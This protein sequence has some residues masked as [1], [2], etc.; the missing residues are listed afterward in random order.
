MS[1]PGTCADGCGCGC[2]PVVPQTPEPVDN[3]PGQSSIGYRV[4]RHSS[5]KGAILRGLS[6]HDLPALGGL[7]ARDDV[8]PTIALADGFAAMA[9]VL[10]FY[11]ERLAHESFLR[12]ATERFSVVELS[13]LIGYRPDPGVA[14]DAWLA[15]TVEEARTL[16]RRPAEP[17]AVHVGTQVQS[18]PGQDE[19][20]V[21]FETVAPIVARA[22]WNAVPPA[23]DAWPT[24]L[25]G[26]TSLTLA[27]TGH[28]LARGDRMLLLG[29]TRAV[30]PSGTDW[31]VRVLVD[32]AEDARRDTTVVTWQGAIGPAI[33]VAGATVHVFRL[34]APMF[35]HNAPDP[36]LMSTSG[37]S[38]AE[39]ADVGAGT[40]NDF[41]LPTD[42]VDLDQ[43][44]SEVVTGGW[45]YV[46]QA[47]ASA[48]L[49]KAT[50]V[51][52][53]SRS[54][55][56]LAAKV[57]RVSLDLAF[58]DPP[59]FARRECTV[60]AAS[61]EL[62]L[63]PDELT[64]AVEGREV[65][66]D[67]EVS[68]AAGQPLAVHG[69]PYG[70]GAGA[71]VV[72]EVVLVAE[73]ADAVTVA[74]GRTTVRLA[75]PLS[76]SYDRATSSFNANVA[77]ATEGVS[78]GEILGSGDATAAGQAFVLKQRPLTWTADATGRAS[79]LDIRVDGVLW[80]RRPTLFEAGPDERVYV[81]ETR[82]DSTT[83][84]RFGDG[85]EGARLPTGQANVRAD[86]RT[87]LGEDGNVRA[88]QVTTLLSRPLG[89]TGVTNPAAATGGEDPEPLDLARRNAPVTVRTL[90]RV[91]SLLDVE[92]F[93]RAHPGI[94]K[95]GAVWVPT[96]PARGVV[97]TVTG[98]G[99][100]VVEASAPTLLRLRSALRDAGDPR[101][102]LALM[103]HRPV[104][105]T[106]ALRVLPDPDHVAETVVAGVRAGLLAAYGWES[107]DL[108]QRTS[109]D[110][111]VTIAHGAPG[112]V[113]VDVDRLRR[114]DAPAG[115]E[116]QERVPVH[117]GGLDA[118]TGEP[119]GAELLELRE[120]N[121]SVEVMT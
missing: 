78:V 43:A 120:E 48:H 38:L 117:P 81:L 114:P 29:A 89:V 64:G 70:S 94:T 13:R 75:T 82:D 18:V 102:P 97:A 8:D 45:L 66:L 46:Q 92:D 110:E 98:P 100:A 53:P 79:A 96:G 51:S 112:V 61:E 31:A 68:L 59:A 111:V 44:Y 35:G 90:D 27:G 22:E 77:S 33:T 57:T 109:I 101:L 30:Q 52:H 1:E 56:G 19:A 72:S 80:R 9:D 91:V 50:A 5:V 105:L 67:A 40:W 93:A 41:D 21:T 47:G 106:L 71:P 121:L 11:T 39:L 113:A 28:R 115:V 54:D 32:V 37:T 107:R 34:R 95:A 26:R 7:G 2:D 69:P 14:A 104:P 116:V 99:G 23:R 103:R 63:A 3:A 88:G 15:F 49:A 118:A 17:V 60:R 4:A 76:R 58:A 12:T 36:R 42:E 16:P 55:F 87:G 74:D 24:T 83:L 6:E 65:V 108:G 73:G 84:V 85:V 25:Q 20:P 119:V 10:T 86:Y 62:S